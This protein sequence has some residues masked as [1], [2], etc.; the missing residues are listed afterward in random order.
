MHI[1]SDGSCKSYMYKKLRSL[2]NQSMLE[3]SDQVKDSKA[4]QMWRV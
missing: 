1:R 2:V 4:W 3:C